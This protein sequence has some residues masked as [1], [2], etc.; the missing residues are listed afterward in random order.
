MATLASLK[1][2][3]IVIE[4]GVRGALLPLNRSINS[5]GR[6][7]DNSLQILDRTIS[8]HH[9]LLKC[10]R[11]GRDALLV[12]LHSSNG[13]YCN[14][15]PIPRGGMSVVRH[16]DL[17]R[18][19]GTILLQFRRL[20]PEAEQLQR[21]QFE[22]RV[23]DPLTGLSTLEYFLDRLRAL[24]IAHHPFGPRGGLIVGLIDVD[25]LRDVNRWRGRGA[26]DALL[27]SLADL[28]QSRSAEA[29]LL[30]RAG[31]DTF[32]AAWASSDFE[33]ARRWLESV[34]REASRRW[35]E[36]NGHLVRCTLSA[37]LG[38]SEGR[39]ATPEEALA[40]AE[41]CLVRAKFAGRDCVVASSGPP[42]WGC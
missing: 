20:D 14:G 6:S 10:E 15:E 21:E 40:I 17:I 11:G 27:R 1:P 7:S 38:Y 28:L 32:A 13:T 2:F 12:D 42:F 37:G 16:G 25:A 23:R 4:G 34:R 29:P 39:A 31:E 30:A 19:G 18:L 5:L 35:V 3:L 33:S 22:R 36:G 8:R 9:A 41:A 26:G 24:A